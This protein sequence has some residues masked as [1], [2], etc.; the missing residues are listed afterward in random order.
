MQ[1]NNELQLVLNQALKVFRKKWLNK[2]HSYRFLHCKKSWRSSSTPASG[3][4]G[5][6]HTGAEKSFRHPWRQ[7]Y[8]KYRTFPTFFT[9]VELVRQSWKVSKAALWGREP[10]H[11]RV[12][13]CHSTTTPHFL[14]FRWPFLAVLSSPTAPSYNRAVIFM[15]TLQI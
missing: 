5:P 12:T 7:F 9:S 13:I 2:S 1:S 15:G 8:Y 10:T 3:D 11:Y 4:A 6:I 14:V